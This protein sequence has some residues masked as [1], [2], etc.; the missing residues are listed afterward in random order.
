M[1]VS[2]LAVRLNGGTVIVFAADDIVAKIRSQRK[3]VMRDEEHYWGSIKSSFIV[4]GLPDG[5][6]SGRPTMLGN[7]TNICKKGRRLEEKCG[8]PYM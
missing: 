2:E 6:L 4:E 5:D 3:G 7:I 1:S 8:K